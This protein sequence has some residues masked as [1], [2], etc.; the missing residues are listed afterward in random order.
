MVNK[1]KAFKEKNQ[2]VRRVREKCLS[3]IK[4]AVYRGEWQSYRIRNWDDLLLYAFGE[5]NNPKYKY[6]DRKGLENVVKTLKEFQKKN[7]KIP[8]TTEK[9]MNCVRKA[10]YR[11]EWN[12][13]GIKSWRNLMYYVFNED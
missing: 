10:L 13:F 6:K 5:V 1:L 7:N 9:E 3:G 2:R 11:C 4:G 8:R 12:N